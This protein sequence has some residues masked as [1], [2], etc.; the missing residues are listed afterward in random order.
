MDYK[1][2]IFIWA[3]V[4]VTVA[5]L[6]KAYFLISLTPNLSP[7]ERGARTCLL[8]TY[9]YTVERNF[10]PLLWREVRVR[11]NKTGRFSAARS[12]II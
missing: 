11:I 2:E 6:S 12:Y 5:V 7:K 10:S 1:F 9:I 8:K 3:K 4:S